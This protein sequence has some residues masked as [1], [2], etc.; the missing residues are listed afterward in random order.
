MQPVQ[1]SKTAEVGSHTSPHP[2]KRG[3]GFKGMWECTGTK[4]CLHRTPG[5]SEV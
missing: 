3:T 1:F 5:A 4:R 2:I